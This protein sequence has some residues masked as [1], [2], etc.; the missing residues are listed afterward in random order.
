MLSA[1]WSNEDW[2][3]VF[4]LIAAIIF[5]LEFLLLLTKNALVPVGVLT[6]LGLACVS[7]GL[8]AL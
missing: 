8:L 6:A 5:T 1:I 3:E 2:S 7:L 4:F